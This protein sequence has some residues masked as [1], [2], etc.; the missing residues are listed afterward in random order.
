MADYYQ[1]TLFDLNIYSSGAPCSDVCRVPRV[2]EVSLEIEFKQLELDFS[3]SLLKLY[4]L[5]G[6]EQVA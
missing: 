4:S 2:E 5:K 3:S 1:L 6:L